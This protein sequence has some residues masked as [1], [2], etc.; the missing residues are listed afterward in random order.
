MPVRTTTIK[1]KNTNGKLELFRVF[2]DYTAVCSYINRL[3]Y[4][5][6][7]RTYKDRE[8]KT[9]I[10]EN[11]LIER[12]ESQLGRKLNDGETNAI[13]TVFLD[14]SN[15]F[16]S[17]DFSNAFTLP[18]R[19]KVLK[20]DDEKSGK[21]SGEIKTLDSESLVLCK[22]MFPHLFPFSVK[23]MEFDIL[24]GQSGYKYAVFGTIHNRLT[25]YN[26][27]DK[28]C[29][30]EYNELKQEVDT[31]ASKLISDYNQEQFDSL[32]NWLNDVKER[33]NNNA[34]TTSEFSI[35]WKFLSFFREVLQPSLL[36]WSV[37]KE[38][39]VPNKGIWK[40]KTGTSI[41]Y[42]CGEYVI[43]SLKSFPE[44]WNAKTSILSYDKLGEYIELNEKFHLKKE[45]SSYKEVDLF[46]SPVKLFLGNNYVNIADLKHDSANGV[47]SI[48]IGY[49]KS[50][51][52][53]NK[54]DK[55]TLEC[56]YRRT[57]R[58]VHHY[59]EGLVVEETKND[60]DKLTGNFKLSFKINGKRERVALL[61][62]P[63][64]RLVVRNSKMD[65]NNPKI[66]DFDFYIDLTMNVILEVSHGIDENVLWK[67]RSEFSKAFPEKKNFGNQKSLPKDAVKIPNGIRVMGIDLGLK[68]PYAFAVYEYNSTG[69]HTLVA[70][71][72]PEACKDEYYKQ[73]SDFA[74][75]CENIR[76][77]IA[78]TKRHVNNGEDL[79][80]GLFKSV[81]TQRAKFSSLISIDTVTFN[82]YKNFVA[83]KK[84]N[85][86]ILQD[87]KKD[88]SWVVRKWVTECRRIKIHLTNERFRRFSDWRKHFFWIRALESFRK[89]FMSYDKLGSV[90]RVKGF[91][92]DIAFKSVYDEVN[93]LKL[94]Y[95]KKMT[96]EVAQVAK[97]NNV[98][99]VV[100][101]ELENLRGSKFDD[102]DKNQ[103]FNLWPVGQIKKFLEDALALYGIL[104]GNAF[105]GNTSQV[106][107][108]T[109]NWGYRG[110]KE[111][112]DTLYLL[113]DKVV[114]ADVNAA[115]N[116]SLRYMSKHTDFRTMSLY[117]VNDTYY[118]PTI[119]LDE[120]DGKRVPG[121]LTKR[122]GH[123]DVV[124]QKSG[125]YLVL[126]NTTVQ[127]LK[128]KSK[129]ENLT[130]ETW[131]CVDNTFNK[132]CNREH[133]D[134]IIRN[135]GIAHGFIKP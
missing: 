112:I 7:L 71:G 131:Y 54:A 61:K 110:E 114:N 59:L 2:K 132:W 97:K 27:C 11:Q 21:K 74:Y 76:R 116:L 19:E 122:F 80:E 56:S 70:S 82:D 24:S 14:F 134:D 13:R 111:D 44:L 17:R 94:D 58:G 81:Q 10:S 52:K 124:F 62:E 86:V 3:L 91:S 67:Y 127:D 108:D 34:T 126:S 88:E 46:N 105:E 92:D 69:N 31:I 43:E 65:I 72:I 84:Q 41:N 57:G 12:L 96:S 120:K 45:H 123:R 99:L 121:F 60:N 38:T 53:D 75:L 64:I 133:R 18:I 33:H 16:N 49:P 102:R 93:N 98:A 55:I 117:K 118:V 130:K 63:S 87:Y 51:V 36:Q 68:N 90:P 40:S 77:V 1:V 42:S 26:E 6:S 109:G 37:N 119:S 29:N 115:R 4:E 30:T 28:T 107:A 104:V 22:T 125:E 25:S 106:D 135:V 39:V 113:D 20:A 100:V 95:I 47:I 66:T 89:M 73:Y 35:N 83:L 85:T 8:G 129:L 78:N 128:K 15:A 23:G 79:D 50:T 48:T 103:L 32:F 101:E 5:M 9:V